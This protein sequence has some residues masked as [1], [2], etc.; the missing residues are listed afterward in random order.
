MAV[1]YPEGVWYTWVDE[2]DLDEL[3]DEHLVHGR[4]VERLKL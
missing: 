2:E 3:V 4:E 1:V